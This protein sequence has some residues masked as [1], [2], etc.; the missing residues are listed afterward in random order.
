[1]RLEKG[2]YD[3]RGR[4]I[5]LASK[6]AAEEAQRNPQLQ[7]TI[8]ATPDALVMDFSHRLKT[9]FVGIPALSLVTVTMFIVMLCILTFRLVM[10]VSIQFEGNWVF[11]TRSAPFIGGSMNTIWITIM[12][13]VYQRIAKWLNDLE[14]HRT[15]TQHEDALIVKTFLFQFTD[16]I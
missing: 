7:A 16:R 4:F 13:G 12:N 5:S 9:Y 11:N 14:N 2:F 15:A 6:E 1:M 3:R 10:S 8:A